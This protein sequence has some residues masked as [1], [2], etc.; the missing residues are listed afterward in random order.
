LFLLVAPSST[1]EKSVLD[2][3]FGSESECGDSI[4]WALSVHGP[5]VS[6]SLTGWV[7]YM[8]WLEEQLKL[9]V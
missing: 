2:S 8:C 1:A 9:K 3:L 4:G 7:D 5:L 6:E